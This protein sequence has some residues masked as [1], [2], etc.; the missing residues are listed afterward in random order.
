MQQIVGILLPQRT[1]EAQP[2]RFIQGWSWQI[3]G[4]KEIQQIHEKM[5]GDRVSGILLYGREGIILLLFLRF[6]HIP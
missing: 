3:V 2:V 4:L 5:N 1:V 6:L